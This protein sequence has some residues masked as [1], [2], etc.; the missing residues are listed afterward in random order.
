[1]QWL[2]CVKW[3]GDGIPN[4]NRWIH[5][6][7]GLKWVSE[8]LPPGGAITLGE[9]AKSRG[10]TAST[11][12][13]W[14]LRGAPAITDRVPMLVITDDVDKWVSENA[15]RHD[16]RSIKNLAPPSGFCTARH[17]AKMTGVN[18]TTV[19]KWRL[20]GLPHNA[21]GHIKIE[22]AM[23][24]VSDKTWVEGFGRESQ[25]VFGKRV[26]VTQTCVSRW[27][28]KRGLP[29]APNGWV[30]IQRGLEWVRDNTTI[31]I[32]PEAWPSANDNTEKHQAAA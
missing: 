29:L 13:N 4:V 20:M 27:V 1:M 10:V 2:T 8:R 5:I 11:V 30:H 23:Q 22:G 9:Y 31:Q 25:S 16:P 12:R 19:N 6:E 26:G 32:P 21:S 18:Q 3:L 15:N 28:K 7:D 14:I 24:W 17:F